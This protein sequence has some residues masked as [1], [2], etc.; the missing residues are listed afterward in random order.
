[1]LTTAEQRAEAERLVDLDERGRLVEAVA[2]ALRVAESQEAAM[3]ELTR[4]DRDALRELSG[5]EHG[6]SGLSVEGE[7]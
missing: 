7:I 2:L 3:A 4:L 1:M 5:E 6:G